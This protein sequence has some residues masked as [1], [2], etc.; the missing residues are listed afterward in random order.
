MNFLFAGD[1]NKFTVF[2]SEMLTA[3]AGELRETVYEKWYDEYQW[4]RKYETAADLKKN[5]SKLL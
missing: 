3:P 2:V 5:L 4:S 1:M